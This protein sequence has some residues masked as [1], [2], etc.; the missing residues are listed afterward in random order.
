MKPDSSWPPATY[1]VGI[2][3]ALRDALKADDRFKIADTVVHLRQALTLARRE[4]S[5]T[6]HQNTV[7]RL[8]LDALGCV[9][10]SGLIP[11]SKHEVMGTYADVVRR[12]FETL[13]AADVS[14]IRERLQALGPLVRSPVIHIMHEGTTLCRKPGVPG[15]WKDGD[16]W[17]RLEEASKSTCPTCIKTFEQTVES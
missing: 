11:S 7:F 5:V 1:L 13:D 9:G 2:V 15:S 12:V 14:V 16:V 17:V 6:P 4:S 8:L 3:E 10:S